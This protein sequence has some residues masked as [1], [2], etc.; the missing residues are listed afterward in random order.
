LEDTVLA[1]WRKK[2]LT[3]T[4]SRNTIPWVTAGS[5]LTIPTD[6]LLLWLVFVQPLHYSRT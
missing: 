4:E 5:V 2:I 6:H 3:S 1:I